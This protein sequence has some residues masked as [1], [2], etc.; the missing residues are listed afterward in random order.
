MISSTAGSRALLGGVGAIA[1]MGAAA[2]VGTIE[3]AYDDGTM[4]VGVGP[5]SSFP[6]D[7]EMLWGNYFFV[8]DGGEVITRISFAMGSSFPEGRE[9]HVA[10]FDDPDDDL[11]PG[12]A[13]FLTMETVIPDHI[14]GSKFNEVDIEPTEVSGGFFIAAF[15]WAEAGIDRPAAQDTAGPDGYSWLLYNPVEEGVNLK[16][17][18][19]NAFFE[20]LEDVPGTFPGVWMIRATGEPAGVPCLGDLDGNEMV[21]GADL[22]V[23]LSAW[24]ECS[25][26]DECPADVNDDLLVDGADLLAVLANWGACP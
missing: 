13:T 14:G 22:L 26:P 12:N 23:L 19:A 24:G 8:E 9:V 25:D 10:L 2:A 3:Y 17:L 16:N 20:N 5:P 4:N 1:L 18:D 6:S 21:N 15:A 7:P 11:D